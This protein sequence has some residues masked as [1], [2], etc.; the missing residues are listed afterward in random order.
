MKSFQ[1]IFNFDKRLNALSIENGVNPALM[2]YP[3]I[4]I[5]YCFFVVYI[6]SFTFTMY[7]CGEASCAMDSIGLCSQMGWTSYVTAIFM[8]IVTFVRETS[9]TGFTLMI[10]RLM[11]E[12]RCRLI[13]FQECLCEMT[14]RETQNLNFEGSK[15]EAINAISDNRVLLILLL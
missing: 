6:A 14:R 2:N 7:L 13:K 12:V 10:I 5:M 11:F 3:K 1:D 4:H 8:G 15:V 9:V